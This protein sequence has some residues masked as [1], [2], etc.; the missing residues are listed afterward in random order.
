MLLRFARGLLHVGGQA[1]RRDG[2]GS[3]KG[4]IEE[5][6][7]IAIRIIAGF[8]LSVPARPAADGRF[9]TRGQFAYYG[10]PRSHI[11]GALGIVRREGGHGERVFGLYLCAVLMKLGDGKAIA[12]WRAT[13]FV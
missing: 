7:R 6:F 13:H 4:L 5:V 11:V 3:D 2:P 9:P 12:I 8:E 10:K 1:L